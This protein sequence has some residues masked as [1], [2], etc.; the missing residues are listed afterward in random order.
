MRV[1][2]GAEVQEPG[3]CT[4]FCESIL[5]EEEAD[6]GN[7]A[8]LKKANFYSLLGREELGESPKNSLRGLLWS[9]VS[10]EKAACVRHRSP[11]GSRPV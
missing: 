10:W 8:K 3:H 7:V 1:N 6:S 5:G 9:V 2:E 11:R 4:T